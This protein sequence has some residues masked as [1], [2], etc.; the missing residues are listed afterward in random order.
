MMLSRDEAVCM[1]IKWQKESTLCLG[2]FHL[3]SLRFS[4]EV[5][6]LTSPRLD[7]K[8][9]SIQEQ[10]NLPGCAL[11]EYWTT[12]SLDATSCRD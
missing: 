8:L 2:H 1:L 11:R 6:F 5:A 3:A 7:L 12:V 4:L 10:S 9:R